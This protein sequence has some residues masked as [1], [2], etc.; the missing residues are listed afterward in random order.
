MVPEWHGGPGQPLLPLLWVKLVYPVQWFG[1]T[2][3]SFFCFVIT[4][5]GLLPTHHHKLQPSLHTRF[6]GFEEAGNRFNKGF[7]WHCL[8][9]I[10]ENSFQKAPWSHTCCFITTR[11]CST[12]STVKK[13]AFITVIHNTGV[14]LVRLKSHKSS[15]SPVG[16]HVTF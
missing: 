7:C 1:L 13:S 14:K 4:Y 8:A 11:L 6:P 5:L 12:S 3:L 16:D 10:T 15:H 9:R 2:M